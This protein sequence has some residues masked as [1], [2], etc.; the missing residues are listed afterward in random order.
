[1]QQN[2]AYTGFTSTATTNT[3]EYIRELVSVLHKPKS[4]P[5][6]C[7]NSPAGK[8]SL[9]KLNW[10]EYNKVYIHSLLL[11]QYSLLYP[12]LQTHCIFQQ[13]SDLNVSHDLVR[14]FYYCM[15]FLNVSKRSPHL[16]WGGPLVIWVTIIGQDLK[17]DI[18]GHL[19]VKVISQQR[20]VT[21]KTRRRACSKCGNG[22]YKKNSIISIN[23]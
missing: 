6:L 14:T 19:P 20:D 22:S 4:I 15:I 10:Q 2:T 21:L 12:L 13:I 11:D 1:M 7:V 9:W 23:S 5:I 3:L 8:G 16:Y 18:R 17:G